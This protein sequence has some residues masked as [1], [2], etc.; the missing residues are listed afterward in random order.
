MGLGGHTR[1]QGCHQG[2]QVTICSPCHLVL[3]SSHATGLEALQVLQRWG[4][5]NGGEAPHNHWLLQV[6]TDE[7]VGA[8]LQVRLPI[9]ARDTGHQQSKLTRLLRVEGACRWPHGAHAAKG[10]LLS[11]FRVLSPRRHGLQVQARHQPDHS[12][13]CG[14]IYIYHLSQVV[15]VQAS[16]HADPSASSYGGLGCPVDRYSVHHLSQRHKAHTLADKHS[17]KTTDGIAH[18]GLLLSLDVHIFLQVIQRKG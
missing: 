11:G 16:A 14:S 17:A 9:H 7:A 1:G 4:A 3:I 10:V 12:P 15:L 5:I 18:M 2:R 8:Q 13:V 6:A